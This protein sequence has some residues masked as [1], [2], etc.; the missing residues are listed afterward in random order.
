MKFFK[1]NKRGFTLIELLVV[2]AIISLLSSVILAALKDARDKAKDKAIISQMSNMISAAELAY[3]NGSYG[4]ANAANDCDGLLS[5][6]LLTNFTDSSKWPAVAGEVATL[7]TCYSDASDGGELITAYSLWHK[8]NEGGWGID[9]AGKVESMSAAPGTYSCSGNGG[10][11][12]GGG[13]Y[14]LASNVLGVGSFY[15]VIDPLNNLYAEGESVTIS[16]V[17]GSYASDWGDD[18]T[19]VSNGADCTLTMDSNKQFSVTILLMNEQT[20]Q[21]D[22]ECYSG[23]CKSGTPP[24]CQNPQ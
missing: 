4:T 12:G 21:S 24:T 10:N 11:Q 20:C 14:S 9:S 7:P 22:D 13:I 19:G 15:A 16:T 3:S 18:C 17:P 5:N 1:S 8:T 6:S 2:V 23:W